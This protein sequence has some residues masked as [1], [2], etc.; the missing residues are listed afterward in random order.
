MGRRRGPYLS[1]RP[2]DLDIVFYENLQHHSSLL[3]IPHPRALERAFVVIPAL[4]IEPDLIEPIT[5]K[6]LREIKREREEEYLTQEIM[7]LDEEIKL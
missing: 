7:A 3:D 5:G 6:K 4:E 2:I 1:D